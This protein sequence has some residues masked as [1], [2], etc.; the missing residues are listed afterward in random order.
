MQSYQDVVTNRYNKENEIHPY[1][2]IYS[3]FNPIGFYGDQALK[4]AINEIFVWLKANNF[5][6]TSASFLDLGCGNGSLVRLFSEY[7]QSTENL[8]GIDYSS[9]RIQKAK[10][11]NPAIMFEE[12][13]ITNL[14]NFESKFDLISAFVVLT[15]LST[16]EDL[17]A[18]FSQIKKNLKTDG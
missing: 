7:K 11:L 14:R 13:D 10:E 1:N 3:L 6:V 15:H 8:V 4:K 18:A 9:L 2:N 5:D 12:G 17:L 16:D